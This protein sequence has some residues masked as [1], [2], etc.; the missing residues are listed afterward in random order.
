MNLLS[1]LTRLFAPACLLQTGSDFTI[2]HVCNNN[3]LRQCPPMSDI[4]RVKDFQRSPKAT[5]NR[6]LI[7]VR[8]SHKENSM[9]QFNNYNYR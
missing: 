4:V 7:F 2:F 5:L 3:F 9:H 8:V 1:Q 6:S